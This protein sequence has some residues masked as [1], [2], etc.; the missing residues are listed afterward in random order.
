MFIRSIVPATL[1]AFALLAPVVN[2]HMIMNSPKPYNYNTD[3]YVEVNPLD[4]TSFKYPCQGRGFLADTEITTVE[5]GG[6]ALP[7]NFTGT[8]THGGGSCQFSISYEDPNAVGGWT[9]DFKFKVIY[10]LIGGCPANSVGNIQ[11]AGF[12]NHGRV[13]G[14]H[15]GNDS[16]NECVRQFLIPFPSL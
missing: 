11:N 8:A 13:D 16:G 3:P 4:G 15:C 5:A 1:G 10:S 12:D 9:P 14:V 7:V 2:S 6:A